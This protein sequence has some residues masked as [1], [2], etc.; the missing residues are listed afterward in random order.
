VPPNSI[1]ACTIDP[2]A[3]QVVCNPMTIHIPRQATEEVQH[4]VYDVQTFKVPRTVVTHRPVY[5]IVTKQVQVPSVGYVDKVV[6]VPQT[7]MVSLPNPLAKALFCSF[8]P[9]PSHG[10][11][12]PVLP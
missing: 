6:L 11:R 9:G 4:T 2:I 5:E 8:H 7:I 10:P 1:T 12:A 3:P